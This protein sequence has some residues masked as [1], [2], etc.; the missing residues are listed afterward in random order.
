[1][2]IGCQHH[3]IS[4]WAQFDDEQI[5]KMY[6]ETVLAFWGEYK[7]LIFQ[8]IETCPAEPTQIKQ[9]A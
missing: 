3:A 1:M 5:A 8:I 2:Q 4:D 6:G 9:A 7:A